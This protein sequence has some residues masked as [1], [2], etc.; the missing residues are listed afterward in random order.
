MHRHAT[1]ALTFG[2]LGLIDRRQGFGFQVKV[3]YM[4]MAATQNLA[5]QAIRGKADVGV[6]SHLPWTRTKG[7]DAE[8]PLATH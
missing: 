5:Q 6:R 7:Q 8:W 3:T 4:A 2:T 1:G